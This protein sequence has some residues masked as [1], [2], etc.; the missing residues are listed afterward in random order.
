LAR[1]ACRGISAIKRIQL[2]HELALFSF[3]VIRE[4]GF[5]C[6]ARARVYPYLT[7]R[8]GWGRRLCLSDSRRPRGFTDVF[9]IGFDPVGRYLALSTLEVQLAGT[10]QFAEFPLKRI[11]Y[12]RVP[13][14]CFWLIGAKDYEWN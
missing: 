2:R 13:G 9:P 5:Q 3:T 4:P 1:P 7:G 8:R 12:V 10:Y 11:F 14:R 6:F